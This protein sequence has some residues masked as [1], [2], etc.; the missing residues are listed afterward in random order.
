MKSKLASAWGIG[1]A[2]VFLSLILGELAVIFND[3]VFARLGVSRNIYFL[4]LW[5]ILAA[6]SAVT[7]YRAPAWKLALGVS[8]GVVTPT[9][10]AAIHYV[11]SSFSG[12]D[13]AGI[14]GA[15]VVFSLYFL[16]GG[17]AALSGAFV[18]CYFSVRRPRGPGA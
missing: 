18:G 8:L 1:V 6:A 3:Y 16:I 2:L 11:G 13:M 7:A 10:A 17:V 14:E 5:L 12:L 9:L 4:F 15:I